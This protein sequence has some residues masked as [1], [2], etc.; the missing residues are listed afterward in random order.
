[1]DTNITNHGENQPFDCPGLKPEGLLKVD[2][3]RRFL[4]PPEGRGLAL[5]KYQMINLPWHLTLIS[6]RPFPLYGEVLPI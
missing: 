3:E 2:T 6:P 4:A 1:M 5:S